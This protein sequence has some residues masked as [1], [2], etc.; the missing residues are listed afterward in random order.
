[1]QIGKV[2]VMDAFN[3]VKPINGIDYSSHQ[4]EKVINTT[5]AYINKF[6]EIYE[7]SNYDSKALD[8]YQNIYCVVTGLGTIYN[9]LSADNKKVFENM[10]IKGATTKKVSFIFVD[11]A[12]VFKNFEYSDW[13]KASITKNGGIWIGSGIGEQMAIKISKPPKNSRDEIVSS[14]GFVVDK[15]LVKYVKLIIEEDKDGK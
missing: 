9:R 14:F 2:I 3:I 13:S 5:Y 8:V 15:G 12:D 11:T 4:F 6:T 1:M 10:M 7:S